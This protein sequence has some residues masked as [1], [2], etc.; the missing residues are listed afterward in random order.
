[1]LQWLVIT[2][3]RV[4]GGR[5]VRGYTLAWFLRAYFGRRAVR[6][7][8]P[9]EL[10]RSPIAADTVFVGLPNSLAPDEITM[11]LGGA[12]RRRVILF[13]Y[14]DDQR[15]AWSSEQEPAF[16]QVTNVYLKPWLEHAWSYILQMGM[17]PIRRS[18]RLTTAVMVDRARRKL[19]RP[20]EPTYDVAFLGQPN[21]TRILAGGE[22]RKIDQRF[23]WLRDI[24]R[25]APELNF[26]GGFVGGDPEIVA[27]LEADHGDLSPY[28]YPGGKVS[29][30]A[31]W[32]AMR[33]SR[34]HLAPGGNAPW[35]YRH[36]ECLYAGGVVVT[37]D[38]RRRDML[39]PLP[40]HGVVHVPDGASVLPAIQE[41]LELSRRRPI[42]GEENIAHLEH[43]LRFGAYSHRRPALLGRFLAQLK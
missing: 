1:M 3:D 30:R 34:V 43:Y 29:F 16:R 10:R 17:L 11:L 25:E 20:G 31:Y 8:T 5:G 2:A 7:I 32:R 40:R 4:R 33:R 39:I 14:L 37:I 26:W 12:R 19:F 15:L 23:N 41:A 38:F 24:K 35:T 13:D 42:V 6:T 18:G 28:Y 21:D 36:Y 27:R 22:V 9:G